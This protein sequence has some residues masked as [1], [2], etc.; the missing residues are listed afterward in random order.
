MPGGC[1]AVN[2]RM[3]LNGVRLLTVFTAPSYLMNDW[4]PERFFHQWL[5]CSPLLHCSPLMYTVD[6]TKIKVNL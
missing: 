4:F 5:V 6:E 1:E 2:K 3:P